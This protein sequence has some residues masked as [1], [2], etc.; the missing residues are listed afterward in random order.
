MFECRYSD[1]LGEEHKFSITQ[2]R[3]VIGIN[4]KTLKRYISTHGEEAC[5]D[6][7]FLVKVFNEEH[8]DNPID[9]NE[10]MKIK[11][12]IEN[13]KYSITNN[14]GERIEVSYADLCKIVKKQKKIRSD[15]LYLYISEMIK[16][17]SI[18]SVDVLEE[19]F[20]IYD[21]NTS[22]SLE[23][24]YPDKDGKLVL[25]NLNT[26]LKDIKKKNPEIA[27][28][29]DTLKRWIQIAQERGAT[30]KELINKALELYNN[31][32]KKRTYFLMRTEDG[33]FKEVI[34]REIQEAWA[35]K[36][37]SKSETI[38]KILRSA[39]A[40][41]IAPEQ[42]VD[43]AFEIAQQ[44]YYKYYYQD[45]KTGVTEQLTIKQIVE[46]V[47]AGQKI[48]ISVGSLRCNYDKLKQNNSSEEL[49]ESEIM[50]SAIE[51]T[52]SATR[53]IYPYIGADGEIMEL[54][55]TEISRIVGVSRTTLSQNVKKLEQN[56]EELVN[57]PEAIIT[58]AIELCKMS[59]K[60]KGFHYYPNKTY[61][62]IE[63]D[64]SI[65]KVTAVDLVKMLRKNGEMRIIPE[66]LQSKMERLLKNGDVSVNDAFEKATLILQGKISRV[67]KPKPV[68]YL[69]FE[70]SELSLLLGITQDDIDD[71]RKR[72]LSEDG[73]IDEDK[74]VEE[75]KKIFNITKVNNSDSKSELPILMMPD[76]TMSVRQ[77]CIQHAYNYNSVY[78][79]IKR[80]FVKTGKY[81]INEAI[82]DYILT[83]QENA[84]S[85]KYDYNDVLYRHTALEMGLDF[86]KILYR[87]R[88]YRIDLK[89]AMEMEIVGQIPDDMEFVTSTINNMIISSDNEEL[90]KIFNSF[91]KLAN[92]SEK[93]CMQDIFGRVSNMVQVVKYIYLFRTIENKSVQ[94]EE[95]RKILASQ[96]GITDY[97]KFKSFV[98]INYEGTPKH[99]SA[100]AKRVQKS[101]P[102]IPDGENR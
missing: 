97:E 3:T 33:E 99:L 7:V 54:T 70:S 26:I 84:M 62:Y 38:L 60:S 100:P 8:P 61:D 35:N 79:R 48:K 6:L 37:F 22:I 92:D 67:I 94:N 43:R 34:A 41:G 47:N 72:C 66:N 98:K 86:D 29:F 17:G 80:Q 19:V 11:E 52:K 82:S 49:T 78:A 45:S 1:T 28:T 39:E 4:Q 57:F 14:N 96:M 20:R 83:G 75:C 25:T 31:D 85:Y 9:V 21:E 64:G 46:R 77:Y 74:F 102:P 69:D 68:E 27:L 36:G 88:K 13:R 16:N 89:S 32:S 40:E 15:S 95:E 30:E 44:K 90:R 10:K 87:M 55:I 93:A 76:G 23:F 91:K 5:A 59:S 2:L 65:K 58:S 18:D 81:D 56:N 53:K 24:F 12:K 42:I 51:I 101:A 73:L 71:L 63:E 50:A